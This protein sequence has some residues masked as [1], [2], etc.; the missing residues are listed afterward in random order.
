MLDA[1]TCS[2]TDCCAGSRSTTDSRR[3]MQHY[4]LP[5]A[6]AALLTVEG[7]RSTTDWR[8][9]RQHYWLPQAH[10]AL[11]TVEGTRSTTDWCRNRQHYW[12]MQAQAALLRAICT[13][14]VRRPQPFQIL[15]FY[16]YMVAMGST[17]HLLNLSIYRTLSEKNVWA[18]YSYNVDMNEYANM[19]ISKQQIA[20]EASVPR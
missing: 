11:L 12:L 2:I 13:L 7:T 18:N 9:N 17:K 8:S 1:R 15:L 16:A 20:L 14:S 3:N 4:W 10:A 19:T 6:Q 5:P